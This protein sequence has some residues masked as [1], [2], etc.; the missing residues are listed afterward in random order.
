[1]N[2]TKRSKK[3]QLCIPTLLAWTL[4]RANAIAMG[5][6]IARGGDIG[7]YHWPMGKYVSWSVGG[8]GGA[9]REPAMKLTAGMMG[10]RKAA[11]RSIGIEPREPDAEFW[12]GRVRFGGSPS[13][14]SETV[15]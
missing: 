10:Q 13:Q 5:G 15:A 9:M 8:N 1:M 14:S 6:N 3:W 11:L 2:G 4:A 12:V 7:M